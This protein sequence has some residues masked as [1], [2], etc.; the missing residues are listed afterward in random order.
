M[1]TVGRATE[2]IYEYFLEH[3]L[4]CS[5]GKSQ[6]TPAEGFLECKLYQSSLVFTLGPLLH[7][8]FLLSF[9][10]P[11]LHFPSSLETF[12]KYT[13]TLQ[14]L[15][16]ALSLLIFAICV[17][18]RPSY[19]PCSAPGYATAIY[20]YQLL[21]WQNA[22]ER[23]NLPRT[24]IGILRNKHFHSWSCACFWLW[25]IKLAFI[26]YSFKFLS[27]KSQN[28]NIFASHVVTCPSSE[29]MLNWVEQLTN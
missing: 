21:L 28:I 16:R 20:L 12:T 27:E 9:F 18:Y 2:L 22:D 3:I 19:E 7:L 6:C 29:Y 17:D 10:P 25:P 8:Y 11:F 26:F 4:K 24:V 14:F 5:L 1:V 13:L 15:T 23:K